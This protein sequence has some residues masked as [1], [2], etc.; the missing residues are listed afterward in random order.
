MQVRHLRVIHGRGGGIRAAAKHESSDAE[1][2]SEHDEEDYVDFHAGFEQRDADAAVDA[3]ALNQIVTSSSSSSSS[4]SEQVNIV[5]CSDTDSDEDEFRAAVKRARKQR[6]HGGANTA[7]GAVAAVNVNTTLQ[8][9]VSALGDDVAETEREECTNAAGPH[10][11]V[12][13]VDADAD[14]D[15]DDDVPAAKFPRR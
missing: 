15:D 5:A 1:S 3:G 11:T 4:S 10:D 7:S 12:A 8:G 14:A 9:R 13:D 2:E 6:R